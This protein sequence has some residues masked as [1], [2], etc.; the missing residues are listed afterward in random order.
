MKNKI[1]AFALFIFIFQHSSAQIAIPFPIFESYIDIEG[2]IARIL[3]DETSKRYAK[4]VELTY[5]EAKKLGRT[6]GAEGANRTLWRGVRKTNKIDI[7]KYQSECGAYSNPTK[8]KLCKER[9]AYLQEAHDVTYNVMRVKL[10][11][12]VRKGV[13]DKIWTKYAS[14]TTIIF[15]ELEEIRKD[16]KKRKDKKKF[17]KY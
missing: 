16:V 9:I 15:G 6:T 1:I 11:Y 2:A 8:R 7:L 14:I 4:N 10:Q 3:E 13:R 17:W 12:P 5:D